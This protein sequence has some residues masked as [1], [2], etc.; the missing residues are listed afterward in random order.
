MAC[1]LCLRHSGLKHP[2]VP[3]RSLSFW[4]KRGIYLR[5]DK[6]FVE[7]AFCLQLQTT[8]FMTFNF[9]RAH[10]HTF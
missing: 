10:L 6:L 1:Y 4:S 2:N 7:V 5:V 3:A 8:Q 9:Y